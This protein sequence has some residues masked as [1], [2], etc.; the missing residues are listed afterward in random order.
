MV[1][2]AFGNHL[3]NDTF[4]ELFEK[5]GLPYHVDLPRLRKGQNGGA[6]WSVYWQCPEHGE[7]FA[8]ET[9][10]SSE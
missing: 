8:D 5:G 6:F 7:D 9:Y 4:K 3:Y 10:Y 1:R 2:A